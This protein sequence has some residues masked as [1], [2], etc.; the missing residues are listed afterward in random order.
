MEKA[1]A[2]Y[3]QD[4]LVSAFLSRYLKCSL[5]SIEQLCA[6]EESA[7]KL[8]NEVG[9]DQFRVWCALDAE[10]IRVYKNSLAQ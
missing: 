8:Y 10:A 9:R 1:M 2:V 6:L 5:L 7:N 4:F 3:T